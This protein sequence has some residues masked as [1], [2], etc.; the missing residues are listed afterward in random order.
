MAIIPLLGRLESASES[1]REISW[2]GKKTMM[3]VPVKALGA[4]AFNLAVVLS[5][6]FYFVVVWF[7]LIWVMTE[8]DLEL[9]TLLPVLHPHPV[10]E[11]G[12]EQADTV[13]AVLHPDLGQY[14]GWHRCRGPSSQASPHPIHLPPR[15]NCSSMKP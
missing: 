14:P 15:S 4:L 6:G 11:L 2:P 1:L 13:P 3:T 5:E 12:V 8:G 10:L 9:L 7:G